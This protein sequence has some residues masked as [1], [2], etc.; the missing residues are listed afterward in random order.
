MKKLIAVVMLLFSNQALASFWSD[1]W[2]V[3]NEPGWGVNIVQQSGTLFATIFVYEDDGSP[4]WYV[5]S[6][7]DYNGTSYSG[8]LYQTKGYFFGG[9]FDP[10]AIG[11]TKVGTATFTPVLEATANFSYSVNGLSIKR[12]LKRQTFKIPNFSGTYLGAAKTAGIK[13]C[14]GGFS[15]STGFG[16][17]AMKITES[18]S[19][20]QILLAGENSQTC[21]Y[22]GTKTQ[23]GK[24]FDI[25][26]NMSC[27]NGASG[28]FTLYNGQ[29][30]GR[31]FSAAYKASYQCQETGYFGAIK[32]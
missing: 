5:A 12:Q 15:A 7:M 28:A 3:P 32:D 25:T 4:T 1:L 11:V 18:G 6:E 31:N 22:Q 26:G 24:L 2:Y 10:N 13:N 29:Y 27:S 21:T 30:D 9:M 20:V 23:F 8:D 17:V 19:S 14:V 16:F